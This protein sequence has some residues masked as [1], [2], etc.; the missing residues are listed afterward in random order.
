MPGKIRKN[1]DARKLPSGNCVNCERRDHDN[2]IR[3][4]RHG[5]SSP[6]DDAGRRTHH[7]RNSASRGVGARLEQIEYIIA[8]SITRNGSV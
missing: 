2:H 6:S 8:K 7:S 1:S 3:A 4:L 5:A